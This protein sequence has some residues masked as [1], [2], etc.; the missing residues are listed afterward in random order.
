MLLS[1]VLSLVFTLLLLRI[2]NKYCYVSYARMRIQGVD[3][4]AKR[5]MAFFA[6]FVFPNYVEVIE[7]ADDACICRIFSTSF[8]W[9]PNFVK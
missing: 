6:P 4:K 3:I 9:L 2:F 1:N 5:L 7:H 8:S